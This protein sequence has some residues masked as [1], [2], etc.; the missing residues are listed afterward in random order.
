M[1]RLGEHG[2]N[3]PTPYAQESTILAGI[4]ETDY[5]IHFIELNVVTARL[6]ELMQQEVSTGEQAL[7]ELASVLRYGSHEPILPF[8]I[9]ILQQLKTQHII[10]GAHYEQ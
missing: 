6:I 7:L 10:I 9:E 3:H 4:R 8:G 2:K 1:S 5:K